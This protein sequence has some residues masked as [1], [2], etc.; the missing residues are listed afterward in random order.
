MFVPSSKRSLIACI[1]RTTAVSDLFENIK[2]SKPLKST[3]PGRYHGFECADILLLKSK[4]SLSHLSHYMFSFLLHHLVHASL[5]HS[6]Q[7]C[8]NTS[9]FNTR[10]TTTIHEKATREMALSSQENGTTASLLITTLSPLSAAHK[11]S[12]S[13][14]AP[15]SRTLLNFHGAK[16]FKSRLFAS[17]EKYVSHA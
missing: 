5:I 8:V 12:V 17:Q 9:Y 7:R 2:N 11:R 4:A 15:A 1:I 13:S 6:P 3:E 10:S 14:S 16:T